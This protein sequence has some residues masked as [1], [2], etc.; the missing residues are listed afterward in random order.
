[1]INAEQAATCG[2]PFYGLKA[3]AISKQP[4]ERSSVEGPIVLQ[5]RLP[6][7]PL[8]MIRYAVSELLAMGPL[9]N[10]GIGRWDMKA[11]ECLMA[12]DTAHWMNQ[13]LSLPDFT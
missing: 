7:W 8:E 4:S 6:N 11:M 12:T 10:E 9:Y 5:E 1:V 2:E 13:W 3:I